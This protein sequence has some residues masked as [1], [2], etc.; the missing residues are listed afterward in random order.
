MGDVDEDGHG[1]ASL[2]GHIPMEQYVSRSPA[3]VYQ[4]QYN[5]L[6]SQTVVFCQSGVIPGYH[7]IQ[8]FNR[9][10]PLDILVPC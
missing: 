7:V 6:Q 5:K 9:F 10:F 4:I 8:P 2:H 3:G 1:R